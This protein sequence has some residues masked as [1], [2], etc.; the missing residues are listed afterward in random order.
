MLCPRILQGLLILELCSSG[1]A[2]GGCILLALGSCRFFLSFLGGVE[3]G[4][5]RKESK[6]NAS[7]EL[8][9]ECVSG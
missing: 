7:G 1:E 6:V 3:G 4:S 5:A 2:A 9:L 8:S